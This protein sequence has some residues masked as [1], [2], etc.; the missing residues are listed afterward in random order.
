MGSEAVEVVAIAEFLDDSVAIAVTVGQPRRQRVR[1]RAGPS[2]G[3]CTLSGRGERAARGRAQARP[4][5]VASGSA[6][7]S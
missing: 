2:E 6:I 7:G 5:G 1:E 3:L 4:G